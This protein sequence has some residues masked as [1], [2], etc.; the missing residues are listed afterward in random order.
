M[1]FQPDYKQILKYLE[2][3]VFSL[4]LLQHFAKFWLDYA[5]PGVALAEFI[6]PRW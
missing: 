6:T 4:E 5:H 1:H 2:T 3:H